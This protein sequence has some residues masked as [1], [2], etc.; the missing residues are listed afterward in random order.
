MSFTL[1]INV[2]K[3][4]I[5]C[6]NLKFSMPVILSLFGICRFNLKKYNIINIAP[7]IPYI[8]PIYCLYL[9]SNLYYKYVKT[10]LI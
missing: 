10:L 2:I 1:Y 9:L 4:N 5:P 8:I 3:Y 6:N 7:K